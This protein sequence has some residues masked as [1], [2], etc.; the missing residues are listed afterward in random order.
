MIKDQMEKIYKNMAIDDIPWNFKTPPDVLENLVRTGK[1][2]PCKTIDLGCGTGNYAIYLASEGF[3]VT[4]VD[5]S[6][7]A[8]KIAKN[9]ASQ[10]GIDCNFTVADILDDLKQIQ[11]TFDF[12]YDWEL[13]HHIFPS[14]RE[15]YI[16]NVYRLLN[17]GGQYLSVCFSEEN[18]QFGRV[19][20]YRKTP[21]ETVLYFSSENELRV[22]YESFFKVEEL[23]TIEIKGKFSPHKAIYAFM[24]KEK[25]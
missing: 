3:D 18:L 4:A 24:I 6:S 13:L 21:L 22:L 23:K 11:S 7:S 8:I 17:P 5:I 2:T 9:N 25:K 20:K 12:A 10:K 16:R 19:G 1:I 15:K 14:D